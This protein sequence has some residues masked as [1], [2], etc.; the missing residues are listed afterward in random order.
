MVR[1]SVLHVEDVRFARPGS[2]SSSSSHI[3]T[4]S[5][6]LYSTTSQDATGSLLRLR[7]NISRRRVRVGGE[8]QVIRGRVKSEG[9]WRRADQAPVDRTE[10]RS[11]QSTQGALWI[12]G[13]W[14][15]EVVREER[16]VL[17]CRTG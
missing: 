11:K 12:W 2:P 16:T 15:G 10:G 8:V 6:I 4:G 3:G 14:R 1:W 17:S 13:M 9:Q 5:T 7:K